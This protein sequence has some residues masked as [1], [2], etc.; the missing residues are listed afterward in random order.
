MAP[1]S[2]LGSSRA[3]VCAPPPTAQ[4]SSTWQSRPVR[5]TKAYSYKRSFDNDDDLDRSLADEL[6][7]LT[8]PDKFRKVAENLELTWKITKVSGRHDAGD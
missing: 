4:H 2:I 8:N 6:S 1:V 5:A 7:A 3:T